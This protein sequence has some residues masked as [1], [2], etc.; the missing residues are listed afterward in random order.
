MS[1]ARWTNG[2]IEEIA[3]PIWVIREGE[4][5]LLKVVWEVLEMER[6][7]LLLPLLCIHILVFVASIV[8]NCWKLLL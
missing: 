6:P 1:I 4:M 7:E 8:L 3:R 2:S 5:N